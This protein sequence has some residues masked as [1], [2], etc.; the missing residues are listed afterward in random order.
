MTKKGIDISYYQGAIDFEKVKASGIDFVIIRAGYGKYAK[1]KD[2]WFENFYKEAK[3]AGLD[4]GAYWFSYAETAGEATQEAAA[5]LEVIKGKKFEYPIY[6]DFELKKQF[7]KGKAFCDAAI[8]NFCTAMENAGYFTG[9]YCSTWWYTNYVSESVRKRY[10]TW[11][12]EWSD[13][14]SY[15]G[16]YDMWQM[17]VD[18]VS[19]VHGAVDVDECYKDFPSIIKSGGFNGYPKGDVQYVVKQG[20]TLSKI[21]DEYGVSVDKLVEDNGLVKVGQQLV[22]R[23]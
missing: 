10:S 4:V 15:Q 23:R 3:A 21:A 20:D 22:I 13:G 19:G 1:Q 12:A 8:T 18:Y 6:F 7:E 17:G 5:C 11:V 9:V 2:V 14:V 16:A